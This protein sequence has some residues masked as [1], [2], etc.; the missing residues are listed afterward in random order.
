MISKRSGPSAP[1]VEQRAVHFTT[2]YDLGGVGSTEQAKREADEVISRQ[3]LNK[4]LVFYA[5]DPL[6][7]GG[8]HCLP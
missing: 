3:R 1:E 6:L 2:N 4:T 8:L 7:G 5:K